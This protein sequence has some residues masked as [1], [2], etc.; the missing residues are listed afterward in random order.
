MKKIALALILLAVFGVT[1]KAQTRVAPMLGY[2][3]K[4]SQPAL[5]GNAEFFIED[6]ISISPSMLLY[7]PESHQNSRW[8]YV[9]FNLNGN[10]YFY[11]KDVFEFYAIGGL[12]Y[13]RVRYKDKINGDNSYSDDN[14][15]L[16]IGGGINFKVDTDLLP[17][18]EIRYVLG[19]TDQAVIVAGVK[20]TIGN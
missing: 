12:N 18:S 7:F 2:A 9:E 20:F 14:I 8:G 3:T 13:S 17:F 1:A 10:Y 6:K 15:N 19:G 11:S 4:Y 5:G 16:N